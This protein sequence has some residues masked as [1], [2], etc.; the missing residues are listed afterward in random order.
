[1]KTDIHHLSTHG[2]IQLSTYGNP[3]HSPRLVLFRCATISFSVVPFP[4][5]S[6]RCITYTSSYSIGNEPRG[7]AQI[8]FMYM[9]GICSLPS[10]MIQEHM[11][12]TCMDR[13]EMADLCS[14]TLVHSS[15]PHIICIPFSTWKFHLFIPCFT[16]PQTRTYQRLVPCLPATDSTSSDKLQDCCYFHHLCIKASMLHMVVQKSIQ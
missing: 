15:F 6:E 8:S 3:F 1:M 10:S 4:P 7:F 12:V 2:F 5:G 9:T 13:V 11:L 14:F 16:G